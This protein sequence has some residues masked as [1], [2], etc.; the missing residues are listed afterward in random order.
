M[1]IKNLVHLKEVGIITTS[2]YS[3]DFDG[4]NEFIQLPVNSAFD[5]ENTHA[6]SFEAW[7]KL[8]D[9]IG[10]KSLFRKYDAGINRGYF[11]IISGNEVRFD[12]QNNGGSNGAIVESVGAGLV[13]GQWHHVVGTYDGSN[14][15]NNINLYLD[16]VLQTKTIVSNTLTGTIINTSQLNI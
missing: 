12:L 10:F 2:C 5:L 3:L 14:D 4:V 9:I 16:G 1:I 8:G 15:A 6:F 11:L 7:V 13:V